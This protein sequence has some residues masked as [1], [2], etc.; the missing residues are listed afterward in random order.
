VAQPANHEAL[1]HLLRS[2][3]ERLTPA[4]VGLPAGR[5]RRT[6]GLRR[7][8]V[9]LLASVST[10]YYTFLEQGRPVRPSAEVLDALA[11]ALRMSSAERRYLRALAYG[12]DGESG[13]IP[14]EQV[15]PRLVDLVARMEPYPTVVKGRRWDVLAANP[16]AREL[17]AGWGAVHTARPNLLLW[18]FT[19]PE[20]HQIYMDWEPEAAAMLGRFRLAAARHPDD[21]DFS[22]L[23]A[24][25][26]DRSTLVQQLWPRHDVAAIA[27]GSKKLRHPR[28]GPIDYTHVVLAVAEDPEQSLITYTP[29]PG[30]EPPGAA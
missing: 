25:L 29:A 7:E 12:D 14:P 30:P 21:P 18:M 24:R 20:A 3:R 26:H 27:S 6:T 23:I 28:L 8:E 5:R 13:A 22:E 2:R 16:A 17:F 15:D 9:A 19:A 11:A 10:T 1:G 4:E